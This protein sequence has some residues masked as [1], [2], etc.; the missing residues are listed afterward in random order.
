MSNNK[1]E[2]YESDGSD[3]SLSTQEL[4]QL[5]T[6]TKVYGGIERS[7]EKKPKAKKPE[8][9]EP[10]PE[11]QEPE[12]EPLVT[13]EPVKKPRGRPKKEKPEEVQSQTPKKPRGRPP[14]SYTN[15]SKTE[16]IVYLAP[17]F[18]GG[19]ERVRIKPLTK[20]QLAKA[21]AEA[22]IERQILE[23]STRQLREVDDTVPQQRIQ[24][25]ARSAAQIEATR[26]LVESRKKMLADKKAQKEKTKSEEHEQIKQTVQE[27]VIETVTEPIDEVRK[28]MD[29][30]R[31]ARAERQR[32]APIDIPRR[33]T[34]TFD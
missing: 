32:S 20:K 31:K 23:D 27:A 18:K 9:Q 10:E 12:P 29:E 6:V 24:K 25:K 17:D 26:K 2:D 14:G 34:L 21:E 1:E 22:E 11:V 8:V 4:N 7:S 19:Y 3:D 13:P 16:R 28:R 15:Q 5:Q 30:R 33:K